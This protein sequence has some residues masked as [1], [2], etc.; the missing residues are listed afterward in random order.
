ML[1]ILM[2]DLIFQFS[3]DD[4]EMIRQIVRL[5]LKKVL[6]VSRVTVPQG[7]EPQIAAKNLT[8]DRKKE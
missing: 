2:S 3:F 1:F 6:L 7:G 4:P 5:L 8:Q